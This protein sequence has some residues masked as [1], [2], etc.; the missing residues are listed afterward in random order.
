MKLLATALVAT[1]FGLQ[2][3]D[4]GTENK[5]V[6]PY[7]A[8]SSA[9]VRQSKDAWTYVTENRSFRF[10]EVLGD[11]GN[12]EALLLIEE[13]FHNEH[14]D[15]VEGVRGNATVKA[16]T[17]QPKR[18]RQ[19]RWAIQEVGNEGAIQDR[20]LRV[21]AWGCCDVPVI[22]SYYNLL[23]GKKMYVSNTDL[24]EVWGDENGPLAVRYVAFGYAALNR[25]SQAPLL[26]FGTD[27]KIAQR[28]SVVSPREYFDAPHVFV[29]TTDSLEKSLDLRG[30]PM[31]F[32]IVLKYEDGVV[33]RIPVEGNVIRPERVALPAGYSL[34]A[35]E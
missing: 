20:F 4:T 28:F 26:Q 19:L 22:R 29:A 11:N 17:L 8:E 5:T 1:L 30:S 18:P 23:T 14:T 25:L 2:T 33:L 34:R 31:N 16:W 9:Y 15:G 7:R 35:E 13:S 12:Y 24:L 6:A 27:K 10:A 3:I 21:T 32:T